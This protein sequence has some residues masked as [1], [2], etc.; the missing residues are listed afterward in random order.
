MELFADTQG[1]AFFIRAK[2]AEL[3]Q[4]AT[5]NAFMPQTQKVIEQSE[6]AKRRFEGALKGLAARKTAAAAGK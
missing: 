1:E 6:S 4:A 2:F 3:S 5:G